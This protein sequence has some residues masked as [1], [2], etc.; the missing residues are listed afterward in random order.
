MFSSWR[1]SLDLIQSS[2]DKEKIGV[3]RVD[4]TVSR[5]RRAKIFE[6]FSHDA[7]L[8]VLLLTISCGAEG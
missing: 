1:Q 6:K 5:Q 2:L 7:E 8:K 3:V 4:G